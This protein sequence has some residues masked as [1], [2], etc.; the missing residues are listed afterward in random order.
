M[1]IIVK[2]I[3]TFILFKNIFYQALETCEFPSNCLINEANF[4]NY[5]CRCDRCALY[6]SSYCRN[7]API[8]DVYYSKYRRWTIKYRYNDILD[9]Q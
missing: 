6:N 7:H 4:K 1:N 2:N 8:N 3:E 9:F 5:Y